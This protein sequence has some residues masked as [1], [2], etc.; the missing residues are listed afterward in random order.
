MS[1]SA[2]RKTTGLG[3][4]AARAPDLRQRSCS[5]P[6]ERRIGR[7]QALAYEELLIAEGSDW[8]WWYG[9]E[10]DSANRPEFDQ[11]YRNHLANVYLRLGFTPPEELSRPILKIAAN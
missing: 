2:R 8:N 9:P 1:G 7:A 4:S 6:R 3:I 11:L 5:R 10:H